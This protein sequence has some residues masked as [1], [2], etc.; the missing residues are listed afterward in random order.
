MKLPPAFNA[1][2][3]EFEMR[4]YIS[5]LKNS[6]LRLLKKIV[7]EELKLSETAILEGNEVRE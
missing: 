5:G 7:T 2:P 1:N 6:E 3:T 4:W